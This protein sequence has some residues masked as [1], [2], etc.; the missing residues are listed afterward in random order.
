MRN[1][2]TA[3][4]LARSFARALRHEVGRKS[5]HE[6]VRLNAAETDPSICH[7]H[8]FCDANMAM[9]SAWNAEGWHDD[10]ATAII[11]EPDHPRHAEAT[12][13]IHDMWRQWKDDPFGLLGQ[14][15]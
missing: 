11:C 4:A 6:I 3:T 14:T 2:P 1:F 8:D 15:M 10:E 7:S 12:A 13:L 9:L 5:Y